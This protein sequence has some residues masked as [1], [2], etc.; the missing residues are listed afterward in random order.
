V[1]STD[2]WTYRDMSA[3]G[4]DVGPGVDLTGYGIEARDGGIGKVD[5]A[6]YDVGSSWLVV[7]TGPWIFG[8]KVLL[9]AGVIDRIDVEEERVYVGRTKDQIKNAPEFDESTFG[10]DAYRSEVGSYYRSGGGG[11]TA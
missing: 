11:F 2:I 5:K 6:S 7:D 3:L 4:A 9:P 1:T 10:D 8:K